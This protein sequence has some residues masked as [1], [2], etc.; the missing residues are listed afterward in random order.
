LKEI[1]LSDAGI[2]TSAAQRYEQLADADDAEPTRAEQY[3][4]SCKSNGVVPTLGG[5]R[6]ALKQDRRAEREAELAAATVRASEQIGSKLYG[7]IYADP[8]WRFKPYSETTGMDRSADNHYPTMTIDDI[9]DIEPPAAPNCAMFMWVTAP[10]LECGMRMLVKW[11]FAY[12]SFYA[13]LKPGA[14]HGYWSQRDQLELLLI[15]T[16][17]DVPAPAMGEQPPQTQ[18]IPR[19]EHSRKPAEFAEMIERMFPNVLRLEMFA[20]GSPRPG[21][22]SW[23]NEVVRDHGSL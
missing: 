2:S 12:K 20:R 11:G 13:W 16:R 7:V 9:A 18:T 22:D 19:G 10:M 15:G 4:A 14:G 6:I 21:W 1:T 3:Y 17:G 8:P 23:G 5:L